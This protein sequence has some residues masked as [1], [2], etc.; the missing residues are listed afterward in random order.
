MATYLFSRQI[1]ALHC[2]TTSRKRERWKLQAMIEF[3]VDSL[4][5]AAL[6]FGYE[7]HLARPG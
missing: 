5:I 7:C 1:S 2:L 6:E 4:S 3:A